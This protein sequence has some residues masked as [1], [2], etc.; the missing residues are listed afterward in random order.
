MNQTTHSIGLLL[1]TTFLY[2]LPYLSQSSD[3]KPE[4]RWLTYGEPGGEEVKNFVAQKWGIELYPVAGCV[5]TRELIDSV[6]QQNKK[7]DSRLIKKFGSDWGVRFDK[8]I[9]SEFLNQQIVYDLILQADFLKKNIIRLEEDGNAWIS[10]ITPIPNSTA[11]KVTI[12]GLI[13]ID[14]KSEFVTF[15]KLSVD[16]KARTVTFE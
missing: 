7:V 14:G 3:V 11:Y 1:L 8:D 4:F 13:P 6:T 2:A 15:Y 9:E 16:Y 10:Q 12:K 5:V